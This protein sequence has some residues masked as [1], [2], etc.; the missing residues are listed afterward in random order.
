MQQAVLVG[1]RGDRDGSVT[2]L[3]EAIA[4]G[5]SCALRVSVGTIEDCHLEIDFEP[6]RGYAPFDELMRP[7]G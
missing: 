3:R 7:K 5:I 6:L 2:A 4:Q 1:C